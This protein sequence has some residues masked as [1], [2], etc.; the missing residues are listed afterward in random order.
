M[1]RKRFL[2]TSALAAGSLLMPISSCRQREENEN[3]SPTL[4][5]APADRTNWAGNYSYKAEQLHTPQSV[6]ELKEL[7]SSLD[8]Q[9]ALG[10]KHCF[11]N[12]ADSPINQTST[13]M[14]NKVVK[15]DEDAKTVTVEGGIRYGDLAPELDQAGYALHNLA[16][17]PHISVVGACATATHGSGVNNGNLAS[18]V[19]GLELITPEGQEI[20]LTPEDDE[21]YGAVV[22]LGALG[23]VTAITLKIEDTYQVQ[24]EVFQDLPLQSA[25]DN[26]EE[27]MSGGYSVSLFTDWMDDKVSQVWVKRRVDQDIEDLDGEYFGASTATR[28]LHPITRLSAEN[29]THQMGI[30][31]PWYERLP[32][33]KMGFT[34][35]SGDELQ[36]E[37]FV[38]SSEAVEAFQALEK[39]REQ[40]YP[41]LFISEIRSIAADD[42]WLSTAYQKDV[43]SFHFTWKPHGPEVNALITQIE[44]ELAP[45]QVVPHWGK[46]FTLDAATL[47]T[48]YPKMSDFLELAKKYDPQG[49]FRNDYLNQNI[50]QIV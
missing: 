29:C 28:N 6:E 43:I 49:R 4:K 33:F 26:F 27:I 1:K 45:Y 10:S 46:L 5:A 14:L 25:I 36:S 44:Q 37:F 11:N 35:S 7:V 16:S 15:I 24:Q 2:K 50:Y 41:H 30:P 9:K 38:S 40:V 31:G 34:P 18:A 47:H 42:L 21:F 32:H 39:M 3:S 13:E 22:H 19:V 23:I 12:I 20:K 17:L 8:T 48:R